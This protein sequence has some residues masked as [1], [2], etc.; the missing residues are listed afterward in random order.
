MI[1]NFLSTSTR[2]FTRSFKISPILVIT[3][4]TSPH[5]AAQDPIL[6]LEETVV[7]STQDPYFEKS[8]GTAF[9]S[10]VADLDTPFTT[11]VLNESI[12][13]DLRAFRL[14][15]AYDYISGFTRSGTNANS[16]TIRGLPADL[17]NIQVDGMPGLSSRFGSPVSANIDR[18]EVLKGPSSVLY[19]WMD[20]G[21]LVN[22]ITKKPLDEQQTILDFSLSSYPTEGKFGYATSFD[23]TGPI[24]EDKTLL[25]R[26]IGGTDNS[27]SF[28]NFVDA[29]SFFLYPGF[30]WVPNERTRLD[31]Q[32]EYAQENRAA[33][34]GLWAIDST[35]D[36]IPDIS[37]IANIDTYYQEPGNYDNDLGYGFSI[38]FEHQISENLKTNIKYRSMWHEDERDL[39][40]SNSI[41]ELDGESFLRRRNRHQY[42]ERNYHHIDANLN[43]EIG[44]NI[45]HTIVTGITGGYEE[46]QFDRL[47]FD[48][49]G[50][51]GY[52]NLI[53]P[54]YTGDVLTDDP[55]NFRHW[56]L[57][58]F[59]AYFTDRIA[60]NDN[61]TAVLGARYDSQSGDYDLRFIDDDETFS[62]S[63]TVSDLVFNG[64]LVYKLKDNISFYASYAESFSPQAI[65]SYDVNDN[66]LDPERGR[67]W[68]TGIKYEALDGRLNLNL[69]YFD[70]VKENIAEEGPSG[71][72]ELIGAI[73]SKGIEFNAQF[74]PMP[75]V[76][77]LFGYTYTDAEISEAFENADLS[78][79]NE[80]PFSPAH[81][82]FLLVRYNHPEE[83]LGGL[84]GASFGWNY[85]SERY[86]DERSDRR[87][88]L[89]SHN[90]IDLGFYYERGNAKYALNIQNVL[91]EDYFVGGTDAYRIYP[92]DPTLVTFSAKYEF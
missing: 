81:N 53:D 36:G 29:E 23:I 65:P 59:G 35:G 33:D 28:R 88:L 75:N 6:D 41:V 22:I 90:L 26:I 37:S 55:G 4:L 56:D 46:R 13:E 61:F 86:T 12:L 80:A 25:Y 76:Q 62:A 51:A 71:A 58:T 24:N 68:E 31:V 85:K 10:D 14:D 63:E 50:T 72:D 87:L 21:G 30:S 11:S 84:V 47:A 18:V 78:L 15:D 34:N 3:L 39:Y 74:Q 44:E 77:A 57:Y 49:R 48:D 83:I 52:I 60:I 27:D 5:L 9:K 66:Q 43:Y 16:F 40:E 8:R 17:R 92:G 91:N 64:G 82:I 45:K 73:R 69:A 42:N 67:Q 70:I 38:A 19:G 2:E 20:P 32:L 7:Y 89:P 1:T 79:G 54:D